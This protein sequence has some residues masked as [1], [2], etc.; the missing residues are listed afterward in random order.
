MREMVE[1]DTEKVTWYRVTEHNEW[2][3]ETWYH[4]FCDSDTVN[5]RDILLLAVAQCGYLEGPEAVQFS[6][7][8]AAILTN[9]EDDGYMQT[10]WFGELT[11][12]ERLT[13]AESTELYKGHIR[14]FGEELFTQSE[15]E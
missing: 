6:W 10:H 12:A 13:K 7:D 3:G 2:E 9:L 4:Y 8:Q 15:E 1:S 14:D 5:V 11:D